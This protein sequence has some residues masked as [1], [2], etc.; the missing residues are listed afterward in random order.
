MDGI[1]AAV[2]CRDDIPATD[3]ALP[4]ITRKPHSKAKHREPLK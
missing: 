3:R 2:L 1:N 4:E